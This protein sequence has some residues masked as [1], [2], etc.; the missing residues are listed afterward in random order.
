M[1][2][3]MLAHAL[4][5]RQL[6]QKEIGLLETRIREATGE[7]TIQL[8]FSI[9]QKTLQNTDGRIHYGWILGNKATPETV[10]ASERSV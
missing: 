6:S 10:I 8:T 3:I 2:K 4:G 1:G 7:E 9:F 5:V